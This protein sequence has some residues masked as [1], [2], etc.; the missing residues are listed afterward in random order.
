MNQATTEHCQKPVQG[1]RGATICVS[2][3]NGALVKQPAAAVIFGGRADF[4]ITARQTGFGLINN[5]CG[6][7]MAL[8]STGSC[9]G[10]C[11]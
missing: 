7:W 3:C 11:A 5:H 10:S 6:A 2:L 1:R 8:C 4:R 9:R